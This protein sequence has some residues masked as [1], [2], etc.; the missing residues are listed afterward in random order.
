MLYDIACRVGGQKV[1][2]RGFV[3][4]EV[5]ER[6]EVALKLGAFFDEDELESVLLRVLPNVNFLL[7][8]AAEQERLT[9]RFKSWL[10]ESDVLRTSFQRWQQGQ[11]ENERRRELVER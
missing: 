3:S 8:F 10:A 7:E 1:M 11:R 6:T 2:R 9:E 4:R 5:A